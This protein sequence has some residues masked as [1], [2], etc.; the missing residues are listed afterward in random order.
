MNR[1]FPQTLS[2]VLRQSGRSDSSR[3]SRDVIFKLGSAV[4][5][6]RA[7]HQ[8]GFRQLA[9]ILPHLTVQR[10]K[11]YLPLY[12]VNNACARPFICVGEDRPESLGQSSVLDLSSCC[13]TINTMSKPASIITSTLLN[14]FHSYF[15]SVRILT[16]QVM[17]C[18]L[19]AVLIW[20]SFSE[21]ETLHCKCFVTVQIIW[22]VSVRPLQDLEVARHLKTE[23]NVNVLVS[24][25]SIY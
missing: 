15:L 6:H 5:I 3:R 20:H 7:R 11:C 17:S 21:E 1:A 13:S 24:Q 9:V 16:L 22:A 2:L 18:V 8:T 10:G 12:A 19:F 4:Q 14:P 25:L 23:E